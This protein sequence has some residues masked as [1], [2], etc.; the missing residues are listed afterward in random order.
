MRPPW[1]GSTASPITGWK[2][3][4]AS[5][6]GSPSAAQW[7]TRASSSSRGPEAKVWRT[8]QSGQI[9]SRSLG[10]D[11][12]LGPGQP[13]VQPVAAVAGVELGEP[14]G[15]DHILGAAGGVD[16]DRVG[17]LVAALERAQHRD[18]RRHAGAGADEEELARRRLGDEEGPFDPAEPDQVAGP[19]GAHQVGRD[20]AGVDQLRGDADQPV[21]A[22]GV[23][24][25]RVGAPVVDA[26]D[27]DPDPQVLAGAVPGPLVPGPDQDGDRIGGLALDPLDPAAQLLGRPER[28]DQLQVV[29]GE[30]RREERAD[31]VQRPPPNRRHLG[32]GA[33]LSHG[34]RL[35]SSLLP[36][37]R[38][39]GRVE[40]S[41]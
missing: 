11:P 20:D 33:A 24:G 16:V 41:M 3:S 4:I 17:E 39:H 7:S 13:Q 23:G 31:R 35:H 2:R 34:C 8:R 6:L 1:P 14:L 32:D 26:L 15:E 18:D 40:L 9:R 30:E 37:T 29:V 27:D 28:V 12:P 5:R 25:Q 10:R 36:R 22:A 19:R 21:G 38:L